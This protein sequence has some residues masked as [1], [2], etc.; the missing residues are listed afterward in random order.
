MQK[1]SGMVVLGLCMLICLTASCA[2]AEYKLLWSDEFEAASINKS[3]WQHEVYPGVVS[4]AQQIQYYTDRAENSFIKDGCLV[5]QTD[6]EK[7]D[8]SNYTSARLNTYGR[9]AL[10]YGKVEARIKMPSGKGLQSK[11][12]MLPVDLKYGAWAAS[13]EIDIV[14]AA[15]QN[16]KEVTGGIYFGGFGPGSEHV[17]QSYSDGTSDFSEDFHIYTMEWQPYELRWYVDGKLYAAQNGWSTT[18]GPYPAPFDKPF[19]L[20]LNVLAVKEVDENISWPQQMLV[21]WIRVYKIEGDNK[22]PQIKILS[23]A[24]KIKTSGDIVIK[25]EASDPEGEL[26]KVQFYKDDE[27]IGESKQPP[28]S[29][30]WPGGLDGCYKIRAKAID[31]QGYVRADSINVEYGIGCPPEPFHGEPFQIPGKI[32][33][34]DFDKSPKGDSYYDTDPMN[35]GGA[36]RKNVGVDIQACDEGGFNVGWML[37]GE[38]M[39]YT[40]AVAKDGTYDIRLRVASPNDDSGVHLEFGDDK[41]ESVPV[42]NTG[43]WQNFTDLVIQNVQ[44][45]AGKQIMKVFVD[46]DGFNLN[47]IEITASED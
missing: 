31:K 7:Y 15:G 27:L 21:D 30:N 24:D 47:Y 22:A 32:E 12:W 8:I 38:W 10:L 28:Y 46:K 6:K 37:K 18:G 11:L 34:E 39:Q 17:D 42:P 29:F 44:L 40:V 41:T 43:S 9:F 19:Y 45:K 16:P 5:I 13:G 23:P 36:Y 33:A 3:N 26:A 4:N 1:L 14:E 25:V 35:N 20:G 2:H